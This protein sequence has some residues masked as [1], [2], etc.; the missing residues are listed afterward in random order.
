MEHKLLKTSCPL[1]QLITEYAPKERD[2]TAALKVINLEKNRVGGVV[3]VDLK[4]VLLPVRPGVEGS[5]Y[6]NASYLQ[7]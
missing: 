6:I 4:R 1:L 7:V 2:M 5:D 3:P